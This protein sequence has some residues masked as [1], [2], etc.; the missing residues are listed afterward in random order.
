MVE[1]GGV[2]PPTEAMIWSGCRSSDDAMPG[3]PSLASHAP[4]RPLRG[5]L[6]P[7]DFMGDRRPELVR[8]E[9]RVSRRCGLRACGLR[10]AAMDARD[11][12]PHVKGGRHGGARRR[13]EMLRP[14]MLATAHLTPGPLPSSVIGGKPTYP[15]RGGWQVCRCACSIEMRTDTPKQQHAP[16]STR[17]RHVGGM[18]THTHSRTRMYTHT[19]THTHTHTYPDSLTRSQQQR[20]RFKGKAP[21]K[22]QSRGERAN[23]ARTNHNPA[24]GPNQRQSSPAKCRGPADR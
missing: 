5:P 11:H 23:A 16:V 12:R 15:G 14:G 21:G 8:Q 4:R 2:P 10:P 1:G 19:H 3:R 6:D 18:Y 7:L 13:Q 22:C 17:Y 24:V 9:F 20:P